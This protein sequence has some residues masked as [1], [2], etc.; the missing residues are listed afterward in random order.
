[1]HSCTYPTAGCCPYVKIATLL[2]VTHHLPCQKMSMADQSEEEVCVVTNCKNNYFIFKTLVHE[3][4]KQKRK[5]QNDMIL[6]IYLKH[7][8]T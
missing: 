7:L 8:L 2:A 1:M 3:K 5:K 6:Y 4:Q